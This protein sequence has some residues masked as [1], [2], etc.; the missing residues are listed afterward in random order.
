M[1]IPLTDKR[2]I[3]LFGP[4]A[5]GKTDLAIELANKHDA[6]IINA[7]SLQLFKDLPILTARPTDEEES[8]APH[9]LFGFLN[10]FDQ[11]TVMDWITHILDLLT[12][13]AK[14][15]KIILVGGSGLYISTFLEGI[16][17]IP[18]INEDVKS[19]V[20]EK[21][22]ELNKDFYQFAITCD[23]NLEKLYHPNDIK[24]LSRGLEV[25]LTSKTSIADFLKQ[26]HIHSFKKDSFLVYLKPEREI[27]HSR[28]EKRF[29][30]MLLRGAIE[31]VEAF[32]KNHDITQT[33]PILNALGAKEI[34]MYLDSHLSKEEMI[35]LSI[36]KTR[37]YAK[38]QYTWFN[39][40]LKADCIIIP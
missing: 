22:L 34:I 21:V 2:F 31:E 20:K 16:A 1:H 37:Q 19:F 33:L 27:L 18:K 40:Q 13:I 32:I 10:A 36:Q 28:I 17:P 11:P 35:N 24:R 9:H 15:K 12:T 5:S 39:N 29:H 23:P 6:I 4:T 26:P 25:F 7:D 8:K 30:Q 14:Y 3:V 38:R